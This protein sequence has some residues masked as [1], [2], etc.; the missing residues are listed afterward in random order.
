MVYQK[1]LFDDELEREESLPLSK[2]Q[3]ALILESM[4]VMIKESFNF[5]KQGDVHDEWNENI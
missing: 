2:E 1:I 3:E 4:S 5:K